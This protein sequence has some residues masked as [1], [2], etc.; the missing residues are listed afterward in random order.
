MKTVR[1]CTFAWAVATICLSSGC[2]LGWFRF[3]PG[4]LS[5]DPNAPFGFDSNHR[6]VERSIHSVDFQ[7]VDT[8]RLEVSKARVS[9]SETAN[10]G[11]ASI[12]VTEVITAGGL[13]DEKLKEYLTQSRITA[14]RSFVDES[15]LDVEATIAEGLS[16]QDIVFY[17]R[18][19]VPGGANSEIILGSGPV[20]VASLTGNVE[21]RT[22]DGTITI[23]DVTGNV[24][25]KTTAKPIPVRDVTGNVQAETTEADIALKLTPAADA[26]IFAKSS[27][28]AINLA[29]AKSVA[30]ELSLTSIDGA[31]SA[32]LAGFAVSDV[33]SGAGFFS[34]VLNGGGGK[35]Q[36]K[37]A[38][39]A[40]TFV[41]VDAP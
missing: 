24:V 6:N 10:G 22:S 25:A 17:I 1:Y 19:V 18:L 40:V 35:I 15:R 28:G 27:T 34:G 32:N 21:I 36:A 11:E 3:S 14:E 41:G 31:V 9:L 26:Q 5:D 39:G 29:V 30:A 16:D 12:D 20:E 13:S 23:S 8:I 33:T 7:G 37:S 38:G 4:D 2:D